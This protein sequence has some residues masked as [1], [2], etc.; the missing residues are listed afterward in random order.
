MAQRLTHEERAMAWGFSAP[1]TLHERIN[2]LAR[3]AYPNS[4]RMRSQLIQELLLLALPA[5]FGRNWESVADSA[6]AQEKTA[7]EPLR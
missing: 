3:I 4:R 5:R 7:D 2:A 6:I 1:R